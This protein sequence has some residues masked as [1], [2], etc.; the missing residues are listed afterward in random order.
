IAE[1]RLLREQ[2]SSRAFYV[3]MPMLGNESSRIPFQIWMVKIR[4]SAF[5]RT[6]V[7]CRLVGLGLYRDRVRL[8]QHR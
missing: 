8:T 1:H 5:D 2:A 7:L 4:S 3:R 6:I